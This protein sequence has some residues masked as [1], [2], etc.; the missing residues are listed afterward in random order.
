MNKKTGN[1]RF[2]KEYNRRLIL[3]LIRKSDGLSCAELSKSTGLTQKS[4]YEI[5]SG[6]IE[7]DFIYESAIGKSGGGRKPAI[8]SLK[9]NAYYSIGVDID[10]CYLKGVLLD[11]TGR[12]I[13]QLTLNLQVSLY[14]EYLH[15]ITNLVNKLIDKNKIPKARL[16]GVG[17]SIPGFIN[18]K[19]KHVVMAPNLGFKDKDLITDLKQSIPFKIYMENEAL[20]SAI[21]EKWFGD[22][23]SDENFICIN[24]KSGIGAGI[25]MLNKPYRGVVGSAGEIGH[26]PLDNNGPICACKNRGCLETLASTKAILS[27]AKKTYKYDM[28]IENLIEKARMGE[29]EALALFENAAKSLG[30]VIA[31]LVNIFNPSK[32]ILGKDFIL[33][34]DFELSLIK[35]KV[36]NFALEPNFKAVKIKSS[37]LGEMSSV[38]GASI[39]PQK[40]IFEE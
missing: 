5:S 21:S 19:T 23:K 12:I 28:T 35:K 37:S 3:S 36:K 8:L 33:Y 15:G 13:E 14:E 24:I 38:L 7:E 18:A 16:L 34:S 30:T 27:N 32:V 29:K 11:T 4:V 39:L 17:I 31:Y 25:F 40:K 6:L 9:P 10:V 22:C 2:L 20:A 26:I 1:S